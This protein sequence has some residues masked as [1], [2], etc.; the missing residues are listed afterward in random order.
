MFPF[1]NIV[2]ISELAN[3]VGEKVV[4]FAELKTIR[5]LGTL[6]DPCEYGA[7]IRQICRITGVSYG[8]IYRAKVNH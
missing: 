5:K 4:L 6:I 2:I 8:V 3:V 1:A 7:N